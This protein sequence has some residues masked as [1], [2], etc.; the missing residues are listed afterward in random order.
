MNSSN[1][2]KF[3]KWFPAIA[4]ITVT[5]A[6]MI[7]FRINR[8]G[9]TNIQEQ[10]KNLLD[11]YTSNLKPLFASSE[12]NN[13]DIFNFAL[14][15]NLPI[16]K[17]KN[18]ILE[19]TTDSEGNDN[20]VIKP[21]EINPESDNYNKFLKK[22]NFTAEQKVKIDSI[23][24]SYK[25]ELYSS[26]LIGENNSIAIDPALSFLQNSISADIYNITSSALS[27]ISMNDIPVSQ[28][29]I[30]TEDL[31]EDLPSNNF[32]K[33]DYVIISPD[34]SFN[35][36]CEVD[37]EKLIHEAA[38]AS[39]TGKTDKS[40][41][42]FSTG[43]IFKLL[44]APVSLPATPKVVYWYDKNQL[45]ITIPEVEYRKVT[46][47]LDYKLQNLSE[48]LAGLSLKLSDIKK[49]GEINFGIDHENG[50]DSFADF[51]FEFNLKDINDL[52][53]TS[54]QSVVKMKFN[55]WDRF[56]FRIDSLNKILQKYPNDSIAIVKLNK[57]N[58]ELKRFNIEQQKKK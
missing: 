8:Q 44:P 51:S 48:E 16:D 54:I 11:Q 21:A 45:K 6:L 3:R 20:Y 50:I 24:E 4:L 53:S 25:D 23:L 38:K 42:V 39:K 17:E 58:E 18:K 52:V 9:Y 26:V 28:F 36:T 40:I 7:F 19:L 31:S 14:Y 30:S 33:K 37:R 34:T 13:E 43:E 10:G 1:S 15:R 29:T 55:E 57:I 41:S 56:G 49:L 12:L 47:S 35:L 2:S 22:F 5:I 46:G 32:V 27:K